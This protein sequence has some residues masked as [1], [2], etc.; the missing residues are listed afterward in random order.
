MFDWFFF[1][2]VWYMTVWQCH[3]YFVTD[4]PD[5]EQFRF[6]DR[7]YKLCVGIDFKMSESVPN[8]AFLELQEIGAVARRS[9][10]AIFS[11]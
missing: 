11:F 3:W 5:G 4:G 6:C 2:H 8:I 9:T 10:S 1:K 7:T